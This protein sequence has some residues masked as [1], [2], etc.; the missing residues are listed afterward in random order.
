MCGG[1]EALEA[2]KIYF[3]NP[4][5]ALP[6]LL[7]GSGQI[8]WIQW[9]RRKEESGDGPPGGWARL[10]TMQSGGWAKYRP[11]RGLAMVQR[12]M[13]KD[14]HPG[15]R[16]RQSYWFD[17]PEGYALEC[18]VIEDRGVMRVYVVT[19]EPPTEYA[20][21]HDRWPLSVDIRGDLHP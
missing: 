14:G 12:F 17:L 11:R 18:L 4:K 1:V 19:T 3:P 7:D 5:A 9:G 2:E 15:E 20:W 16:N 10:S 6:V 21:I 13:E 8:D